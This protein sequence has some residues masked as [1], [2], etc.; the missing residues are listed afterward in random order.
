MKIIDVNFC[1]TDW[2][3][4]EKKEYSGKIGK[5]IWRLFEEGNI[6]VRIVDYLPGYQADH[7]CNRGHIGYVLEG[8]LI[9]ELNDGR[10]YKLQPG[11]SFQVADNAEAHLARTDIGARV[12]LV[13]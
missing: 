9:C 8:E 5:S 11:M 4:I 13:D 12:F 1:I 7:W 6:R 3:E 2:S 10:I